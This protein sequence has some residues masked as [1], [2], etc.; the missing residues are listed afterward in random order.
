MCDRTTSKNIMRVSRIYIKE[1]IVEI[2]T[3]DKHSYDIFLC[4]I[5]INP[6]SNSI[7]LS[8]RVYII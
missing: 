4:N 8:N 2:I 3:I 6:L 7:Q 5:I 1:I